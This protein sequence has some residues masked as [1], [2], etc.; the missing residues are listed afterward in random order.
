[1]CAQGMKAISREKIADLMQVSLHVEKPHAT[2]PG[3]VIGELGGPALEL[4]ELITK[5]LNETGDTLVQQR[6]PD[7]GTFVAE[8]LNEAKREGAKS[9]GQPSAEVVLER[10]SNDIA[11]KSTSYPDLHFNRLYEPS[12]RSKICIPSMIHVRFSLLCLTCHSPAPLQPYTSS[13][14][15]FFSFMP[16]T[17]DSALQPP[18]SSPFRIPQL[19][20]SSLITSYHPC[21][22]ILESS[23]FQVVLLENSNTYSLSLKLHW[24][25]C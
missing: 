8:A 5:V 11:I 13:R 3:V 25:P 14:K 20:L 17:S 21:S 16:F 22:F 23:T 24:I 18:T 19:S 15:L 4:V 9:G 10:V 2:L 1:M 12:L 6:Y 7:L